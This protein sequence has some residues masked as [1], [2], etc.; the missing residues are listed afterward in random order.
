[1]SDDENNKESSL[2]ECGNINS[3]KNI[4]QESEEVKK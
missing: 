3:E 4:E 1:M 2:V